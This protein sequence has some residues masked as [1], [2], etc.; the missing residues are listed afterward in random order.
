MNIDLGSKIRE[1]RHRDKRTQEMLA[2]TLGVT[3]QAV[4]RWE[5]GG[6]YPDLQLMP[7]I[8]NY[9]GVTIDEL[10]GYANDREEKIDRLV[11]RVQEMLDRNRGEDVNIDQCIALSRDALVEFPGNPKLML[12][13]A[14]VLYKAAGVRYGE[15]HLT[16]KEGY[17]IYDTER[18][19]GYAEWREA[20]K[21]Y[22]KVLPEL[23]QGALRHKAVDEL[24][25]LYVNMGYHDKV[26]D[27]VAAAP[28]LLGTREFLKIYACDGREQAKAYGEAALRFV[29]ASAALMVNGT[30]ACAHNLTA[31]E[32][33]R[34]IRG[35][36]GLFDQ[37]CV[38]GDY[39]EHESFLA[40]AHLLLSVYLWLDAQRDEAFQAL[41]CALAHAKAFERVCGSKGACY[42]SPLLRL[43]EMDTAMGAEDGR[44]LTESMAENWPWWDVPE[45]DAVQREM[46]ADP[47]WNAW[48]AQTLA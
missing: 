39:G 15:Y 48:V 17:S 44:F 6:S 10:F 28:D 26:M 32:K 45:Q 4:S 23:P 35:A 31:P 42:T 16:D 37:I 36:I 33:V 13:L 34:S 2:E 38:D 41:D 29:H 27:L 5:S 3:S 20:V 22:E 8:A 7:A 40:N 47:R 18:H 12:C 43:V 24:T 25:Q 11:N 46:Q 1:L 9:F 21:L 19:R 14:S 30:L